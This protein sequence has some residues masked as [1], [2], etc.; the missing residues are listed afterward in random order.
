MSRNTALSPTPASSEP[1]E[2]SAVRLIHWD[3]RAL[4]SELASLPPGTYQV[5][6]VPPELE[7]MDGDDQVTDATTDEVCAWLEGK[8]PCPW[9]R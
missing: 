4:P 9:P 7:P 3:G 1:E 6:L 8:T 2:R 5:W